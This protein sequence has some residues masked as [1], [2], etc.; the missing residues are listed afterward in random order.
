MPCEF[1]ERTAGNGSMAA[2]FQAPQHFCGLRRTHCGLRQAM[3][4][5]PSDSHPD[6]EPT[7]PSATPPDAVVW[8]WRKRIAA[9][10]ESLLRWESLIDEGFVPDGTVS[11]T[12]GQTTAL[13]EVFTTDASRAEDLQLAYGGRA[14]TIDAE[15]IMQPAP[16][17]GQPLR[18]R[19]QLVVTE[20]I[21]MTAIDDLRARFPKRAVLSFPPELAFG[22]G[23]H[24]TTGTCLRLLADIA[25]EKRRNALPWNIL[26]VGHG[27]GI[28]AIAAVVL[29]AGS[30]LGLDND[31]F[32]VEV[33]KRNARRHDLD[34]SRCQFIAADLADWAPPGGRRYE[35]VV[36]NL[37]AG[38]L[39][40]H[41]QKI[42]TWLAADGDLVVSGI[43]RSQVDQ[44]LAAATEAG[45]VFD[46]PCRSGKWV[47]MRGRHRQAQA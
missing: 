43:L 22:T 5:E 16:G 26:D 44:V 34:A 37:F 25:A 10:P 32:A 23:R 28:L 2:R 38:L 8:R 7:A 12:A 40:E 11:Q 20:S 17:D 19:D 18:I 45:L 39:V 27:T 36:A 42:A 13:V 29:G 30:G 21:E 35:V 3:R 4:N 1:R 46:T 33:G 14:E 24:G 47:A 6:S 41:L 31:E 15:A 9:D